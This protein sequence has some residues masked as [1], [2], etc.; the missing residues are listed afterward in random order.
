MAASPIPSPQDAIERVLA[1][2]KDLAVLPQ[3]VF[4]IMEMTGNDVTS[5][6]ELERAI[7]VDPG[8]STKLL[9]LANSAHFALPKKVASI[10]EAVMFVGLRQVR[11]TAM[12]VGVFDMFVGKNDRESLR[13]RAWWRTSV[14]T[15]LAARDLAETVPDAN[16]DELYTCGL[17]HLIGKTILDRFD[18]AEFEKIVF[19]L[20]KGVAE[21]QS[22]T[23]VFGCDHALLAVAAAQKWGLPDFIAQSLEY[24]APHPTDQHITRNRA[25]VAIGHRCA[26]VALDGSKPQA[27]DSPFPDWATEAVGI[28]KDRAHAV[29]DRGLAAIANGAHLHP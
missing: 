18:P 16:P 23:A 17:L 13:R 20:E 28:P 22:E 11:Q 19:L 10:K 5:A 14:D 4:K 27:D 1:K 2:T 12:A 25:L 6:V 24:G 3:V 26:Q 15:A 9:A 7:V 29:I 8:F 21:R